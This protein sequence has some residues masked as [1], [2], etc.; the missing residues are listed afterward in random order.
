[1]EMTT[2]Y[3]ESVP[4]DFSAYVDPNHDD[5]TLVLMDYGTTQPLPKKRKA[6]GAVPTPVTGTKRA[7]AFC[8]ELHKQCDE[9][10]PCKR[11]IAHGRGHL[12]YTPA[13]KPKR[14]NRMFGLM[15]APT[16]MSPALAP[17]PVANVQHVPVVAASAGVDLALQLEE[18]RRQQKQQ[19]LQLELQIQ[20]LQQQLLQHQQALQMQQQ[21]T[22]PPTPSHNLFGSSGGLSQMVSSYDSAFQ[23]NVHNTSTPQQSG[24]MFAD[25]H[26]G[27]TPVEEI[28]SPSGDFESDIFV[29]G[30]FNPSSSMELF[31]RSTAAVASSATVADDLIL[32]LEQHQQPLSP[33]TVNFNMSEHSSSD[34]SPVQGSRSPHGSRAQLLS[35]NYSVLPPSSASESLNNSGNAMSIDVEEVPPTEVPLR[36]STFFAS[37]TTPHNAF[38]PAPSQLQGSSSPRSVPLNHPALTLMPIPTPAPDKAA[39]TC[40]NSTNEGLN[41][42]VDLEKLAESVDKLVICPTSGKQVTQKQLEQMQEHQRSGSNNSFEACHSKM[43]EM[44]WRLADKTGQSEFSPALGSVFQKMLSV[45]MPTVALF[46]VSRHQI[47]FSAITLRLKIALQMTA[48]LQQP[49]IICHA[50]T[51][52]YVNEKMHDLTGGVIAARS[53]QTSAKFYDFDLLHPDDAVRYFSLTLDKIANKKNDERLLFRVVSAASPSGF[54]TCVVSHS[55]LFEQFTAMPMFSMLTFTRVDDISPVVSQQQHLVGSNIARA[56]AY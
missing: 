16:G 34:S 26:I 22:S 5:K 20:Q 14:S 37:P 19:Q 56:I 9:E 2:H 41:P 55:M 30:D 13:P 53:Q 7:C 36:T 8:R 18:Q 47:D 35:N 27:L 50:R 17:E 48:E 4:Q 40:S 38:S 10:R 21:P 6:A 24:D 46:D 3:E 44:M 49:A 51:I 32:H 1:M 39:V 23:S 28:S 12:C 31:L 54:V 25:V 33:S 15:N 11:C 43:S 42:D 29:G 52:L 45:M